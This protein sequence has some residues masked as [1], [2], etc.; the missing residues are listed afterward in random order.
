MI[1]QSPWEPGDHCAALCSPWDGHKSPSGG[2]MRAI[3]VWIC[4]RLLFTVSWGYIYFKSPPVS[5]CSEW[6][7][8]ILV[9]VQ[10]SPWLSERFNARRYRGTR[11]F[12]LCVKFP[13]QSP[14]LTVTCHHSTVEHLYALCHSRYPLCLI[15]ANTNPSGFQPPQDCV[16]DATQQLGFLIYFILLHISPLK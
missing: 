8:W 1:T 9:S 16:A 7:I 12:L 6:R 10:F 14:I 2:D 3:N 13:V 11:G 15:H 5:I 4:M